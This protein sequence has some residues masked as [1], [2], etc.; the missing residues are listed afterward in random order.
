MFDPVRLLGREAMHVRLEIQSIADGP[1]P[2]VPLC[3]AL[4]ATG[5]AVL[6]GNAVVLAS[7]AVGGNAGEVITTLAHPLLGAVGCVA[8]RLAGWRYVDLG[9]RAPTLRSLSSWKWPGA[10]LT[11]AASAGAVFLASNGGTSDE[12]LSVRLAL[13]RLLVG[14]ALGEELIHRGVLLA[15]WS[16]TGV[17]ARYVALA[18]GLAFGCWHLAGAA[19]KGPLAVSVEF[20]ATATIGTALFLWGRCRSRSM[21]GAWLLHS[22]TNITGGLIRR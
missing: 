3:V 5:G 12:G 18:N 4:V 9:L 2:H 8:L 14:T 21:A 16:S 7:R 6:W 10:L 19:P 11:A 22:S 17:P 1:A 20:G 15:L 13:V